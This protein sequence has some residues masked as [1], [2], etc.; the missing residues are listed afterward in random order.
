MLSP[1]KSLTNDC[2]FL[3]SSPSSVVSNTEFAKSFE[4]PCNS[5]AGKFN[6]RPYTSFIWAFVRSP[7]SAA[8]RNLVKASAA[9]ISDAGTTRDIS[10]MYSDIVPVSRAVYIFLR[11][12]AR[13]SPR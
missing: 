5:S 13:S 3:P 11:L 9:S 12:T 10:E 1:G 2:P 8:S 7:A 6:E 4:M